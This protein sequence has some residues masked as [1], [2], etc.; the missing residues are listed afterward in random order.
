VPGR[1]RLGGQNVT[2]AFIASSFTIPFLGLDRPVVDRT[3]LSGNFNFVIEFTPQVD[4]P[5]PAGVNFEPDP[6]GPTFQEA[7]KEQAGLKLDAATG[8]VDV[9]VFDHAEAPTEN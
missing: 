6:A 5:L 2:M 7:L 1:A 9:V 3:G 4:A 8:P